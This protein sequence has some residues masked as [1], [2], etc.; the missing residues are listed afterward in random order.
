MSMSVE[1]VAGVLLIS[2][3]AKKL[4]DFYVDVLQ[5]PL[6]D[7]VHDDVPLHYACELGSTHFAIHPADE[8]PGKATRDAQS[9]V[10][11]LN[12]NDVS[13]L[14]DRLRGAGIDPNGPYDHGFAYVVSF[15]D[16]DG[17]HVEIL[18]AKK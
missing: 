5:L 1:G 16:P 10:I 3:E 6:E 8:W 2:P 18:Q 11:L 12:S 17:N 4:R 14:A 9:P 15:R 7:E 13:T